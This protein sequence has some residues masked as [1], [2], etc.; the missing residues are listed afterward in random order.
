MVPLQQRD[1]PR[2][3]RIVVP[4]HP[5]SGLADLTVGEFVATH[6]S[7]DWRPVNDDNYDPNNGPPFWIAKI[8]EID[9]TPRKSRPIK[10]QY[11]MLVPNHTRKYAPH[12]TYGSCGVD[13]ILLHG[14]VFT[15]TMK[16]KCTT[17]RK[18]ARVLDFDYDDFLTPGVY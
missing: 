10:L 15:T 16:L 13:S 18:L 14:F 1:I 6:A 4:D 5:P 9:M 3:A 8:S 11:Y 7:G 2:R 12:V 17:I